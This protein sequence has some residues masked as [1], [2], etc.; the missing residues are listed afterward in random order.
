MRVCLVRSSKTKAKAKVK[1]TESGWWTDNRNSAATYC[2]QQIIIEV[3][4]ARSVASRKRKQNHDI[5]G[6]DVEET[7]QEEREQNKADAN[8]LPERRGILQAECAI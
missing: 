5:K 4:H 3:K 6:T 8:M 2:T 7:R 1:F